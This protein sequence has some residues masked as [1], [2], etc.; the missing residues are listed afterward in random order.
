[1]QIPHCALSTK[2]LPLTHQ[3]CVTLLRGN[4]EDSTVKR[5]KMGGGGEVGEK[6]K[7]KRKV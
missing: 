4:A 5:Y 3:R 1:M 7:K 6:E 2:P